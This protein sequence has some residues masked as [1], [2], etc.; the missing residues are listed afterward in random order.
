MTRK[1]VKDLE[2]EIV[3]LKQKLENVISTFD[4]L[5]MK[6][7]TLEA[8]VEE[9]GKKRSMLKCKKCVK[10]FEIPGDLRLHILNEHKSNKETFKCSKC[11]K[12]FN[13]EWKLNANAKSH[14]QHKCE[15]CEQTF[16]YE[17]L[18]QKHVKIVHENIKLYCH[19]FNNDKICPKE[20][21]CIFLHEESA[22]CKYNGICE[23]EYCMYR[24]GDTEYDVNEDE[25]KI[26][27][28]EN[29]DMSE[30]DE[31]DEDGINKTFFNPSQ[32]EESD[33]STTSAEMINCG[34]CTLRFR[35]KRDLR[36][37]QETIHCWC[38][39]CHSTFKTKEKLEN[40]KNEVH[41]DQ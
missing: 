12:T 19:F 22:P 35:S 37:H 33:S 9:C 28:K 4:T 36:K 24:H 14:N 1:T 29:N 17:N 3:Q 16:K 5:Q 2:V 26:D 10:E 7:E 38:S 31:I 27:D 41:S 8:K 34:I 21:E 18:K 25:I 40:H 20:K 15:L 6:Y 13:E 30:D 39:F 11:G 32:S 23:R